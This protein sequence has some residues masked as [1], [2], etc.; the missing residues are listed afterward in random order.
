MKNNETKDFET[1]NREKKAVKRFIAFFLCSL[2][3]ATVYTQLFFN[4]VPTPSMRPTVVPGTVT[5]G[6]RYRQGT[7]QRFDIVNIETNSSQALQTKVK[8]FITLCKRVIGLGGEKVEI[9]D[10]K[11]YINDE[12]VEES[13]LPEESKVGN[14]G[15]YY[16]PE[17]CV[18]IMG[19]NRKNSLDSRLLDEPFFDEDAIV[20]VVYYTVNK[21]GITYVKA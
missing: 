13:F 17:G 3:F 1:N 15:P 20:S 9:I 2:S 14:F 10:G 5:L 16:V 6:K 7:I 4:I 21:Q 8:P 19:D 18:L 12:Y 11:L